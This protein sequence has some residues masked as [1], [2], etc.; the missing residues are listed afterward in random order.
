[1][2]FGQKENMVLFSEEKLYGSL[3]LSVIF[4]NALL[5]TETESISLSHTMGSCSLGFWKEEEL[6]LERFVKLCEDIKDSVSQ[7]KDFL[8]G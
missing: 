2:P 3:R 6:C 8:S 7:L 5:N 4:D 1:M